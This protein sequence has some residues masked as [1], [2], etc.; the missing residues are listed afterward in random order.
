MFRC[1]FEGIP[2]NRDLAEYGINNCEI[3][4]YDA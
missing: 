3:K 2:E 4:E 1:Y